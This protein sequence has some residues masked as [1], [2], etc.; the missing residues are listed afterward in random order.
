MGLVSLFTLWTS[1]RLSSHSEG[2]LLFFC[3]QEGLLLVQHLLLV[4]V[5]DVLQGNELRVQL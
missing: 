2:L 4:L 3:F 1:L 5:V